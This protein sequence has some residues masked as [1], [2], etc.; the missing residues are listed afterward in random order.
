MSHPQSHAHTVETRREF[1]SYILVL[2]IGCGE[3]F[4]EIGI[5]FMM[6]DNA[7]N[8]A[9]G[10]HTGGDL[11][12]I[13]LSTLTAGAIVALSKSRP[14]TEWELRSFMGI[15]AI[16]IFLY[17]GLSVFFLSIERL[18]TPVEGT[19][20]VAFVIGF[21]SMIANYYKHSL[22]ERSGGEDGNVTVKSLSRHV[23]IDMSLGAI[24]CIGGL[25]RMMGAY[26]PA[27]EFIVIR[28]DPTLSIIVSVWLLWSAHEI[29]HEV[30]SGHVM[31]SSH[32]HHDH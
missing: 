6:F 12:I 14:I 21:V 24:A 16:F 31:A 13:V 8:A 20:S 30:L 29:A 5:G 15:I 28:I 3:I 27:W 4:L 26:F 23:K 17:G 10:I 32:D 19:A 25:L 11:I 2:F 9:G 1:I 18:L 7:I 22:L